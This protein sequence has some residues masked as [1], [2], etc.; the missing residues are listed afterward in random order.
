MGSWSAYTSLA[1][2]TAHAEPVQLSTQ[3][4]GRKS[5]QTGDDKPQFPNIQGIHPPR[6][7][8]ALLINNKKL[9]RPKSR[10]HL[11]IDQTTH[12][13]HK[14]YEARQTHSL[15]ELILAEKPFALGYWSNNAQKL[16]KPRSPSNLQPSRAHSSRT[17]HATETK[18]HATPA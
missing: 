16:H 9:L 8:I 4:P 13:N 2:T 18:P 3:F 12:R 7:Q 10:L 6:N 15:S 1:S 11:V 14:N 17:L 5:F